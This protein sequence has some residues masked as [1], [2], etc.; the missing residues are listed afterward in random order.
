MSALKPDVDGTHDL[1][2]TALRWRA[3]HVDSITTAEAADGGA[4]C[5]IGTNLVV[6]GNLTVNGDTTTLSTSTLNVEDI[7]ITVANGAA[8]SAA[9]DG[10]GLLVDG[11]SASLL[12]SH[13]GTQWE[14]NK[15][16]EITGNVL[17][18]ANV[19]HDLG[20]SSLGWNDL[21]LGDGGV[22]QLGNDQDVTLTHIP[23]TG[24][25]LNDG[26]KLQFRDT[27]EYLHSDG[28]GSMTLEGASAVKLSVGTN[29][30]LSVDANSVDLAQ[31]LNVGD[32]TA[33]T[34]A[35][36]GALIV[37]GGMGLAGDAH[38]GGDLSLQH[39]AA[40]LHLGADDDVS[41]THVADTGLLLNSSRQLQFGDS[42][43]YIHQSADGQLDAVA[44]AELALTAPIV[45]IDASTA[46]RISNDLELDSDAAVLKFGADGDVSLT[47]VAD[48]GLLLN[49]SSQLRFR[50][51][52]LLVNSSA[53]GQLDINSDGVLALDATTEIAATTAT[54]DLDATGAFQIDG[55]SASNVTVDGGNLS[56]GTT[57]S[58]ELDLT[59]AG[60]L[61]INGAGGV[62]IDATGALSLDGS[63]GVNI[64]TAADVA[65][66]MNSAALDIDAS[67][68][69]TID[70]TS[71]ISIGGAAA[72]GD[73]SIGTNATSRNITVGSTTG[74]TALNLNAGSTG[75]RMGI[76]GATPV[77]IDA[78]TFDLD[79]SGAITVDGTST[80]SL[81]GQDDTNLTMT[82]NDGV[83]KT[84]TISA[85]NTGL[86]EGHLSLSSDSQVTVTDGTAS[87]TLNGGAS[88][89]SGATT[90]TLDSTN[91]LELNSS[92]GAISI[93]SDDV[94]Q[95]INIGT[96]GERTIVLGTDSGTGLVPTTKVDMNAA[97][98]EADA[99]SQLVLSSEG[100]ALAAIDIDSAGGLDVDA[101]SAIS[102]ATTGAA[103]HI[104]LVSAHTAGLAFHIDA[105]ANASSEVQID[106][107]IL[108]IDVTG[109]ADIDAG[110]SLS[111]QGG[112]ASDFTTSSGA[113]TLSG[114][115]G[116]NIV[117]NTSEIDISTG[118]TL[119]INSG[120]ATLDASSLSIDSTDTTNLTMT[121][122]VD[123]E[124]VLTIDALNNSTGGSASAKIVVGN[125]SGT[126]VQIGHTTSE[127]TIGQN[128]TVSGNLTVQ[129]TQTIVNTVTMEAANAIRFDGAT[130]DDNI[131][132][133]LTII[134]PDANRTIS[135]PNQSGC[136]P[137]LAATSATQ[138]TATP[139]ELN[140]V[141]VT[142]GT[143]AASKAL[144]LD[145]SSNIASIGTVGCGAITSTDA[146]SFGSMT[147][148]GRVQ[149]N[150]ETEATN[151]LDGSLQ[152][153]GGLSVAKSAVIGDDL[154]LLSDAAIISFGANK[155]V[156]LT[157][158][159]DTGLLLNGESQLQFRDGNINIKSDVDG[160]LNLDADASIDLSIGG[161][162]KLSI[163]SSDST[164][165]TNV[166]VPDGASIGSA[167]DTNA[168]TIASDGVVAVTSTVASTSST[169]GALKVAGGLGVNGKINAQR[170]EVPTGNGEDL[171]TKGLNLS[172]R[173]SDGS[174]QNASISSSGGAQFSTLTVTG[175][176]NFNNG[177]TLGDATSDI[178]TVKGFLNAEGTTTFK[179]SLKY[180]STEL[181]ISAGAVTA[182]KP[183]HKI[184]GEGDAS[185]D[186]DTINGGATGMILVIQAQ[187]AARTITVKHGTGNI[188]L[189]GA[190]DFALDNIVNTLSLIYNGS[191]WCEIGRSDI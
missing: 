84:L 114:G 50:D 109:N 97:T 14:L 162:D 132:T 133:T 98:I 82:A 134:D 111:L 118:G 176:V 156:T 52:G 51:A 36:T 179:G 166:I 90:L 85:S 17:P 16:L 157:H 143:A 169:T 186:L 28:V 171:I 46:V 127:V 122:D 44:D 160:S 55:G 72:A 68:A 5:T 190:A 33:S 10:A 77:D 67:G 170:L 73:I 39:D 78:T 62:D 130:G 58:G 124:R 64:G 37:D 71:T 168:I 110:S 115:D 25:R 47:H 49:A 26:M 19:T 184:D 27:T 93:G 125:T 145:A 81:D 3:L 108:D 59:S 142:P 148:S 128:L 15:P 131:F 34:S 75:I 60:L 91:A 18:Q 165:T 95:N 119:D 189:N 69:I 22:I 48:T 177:V 11:A 172:I 7:Q 126:A 117:G 30:V 2:T 20:S 187:D 107:G 70:G 135:L 76:A 116:V 175:G 112:A 139:E 121:A 83:D 54:F 99:G 103:G 79:A 155:D 100:V 92:A 31:P 106:A 4:D 154:D 113:L 86:G 45:D 182:A 66:D 151:L 146:S 1:G 173:N 105:N 129:G 149:V 12:Y 163:T 120:A 8:D 123:A 141:D 80:L 158:V 41:L 180:D 35:T 144:V 42:A 56:I 102:L 152:T 164:F 89:I 21:Y 88:S 188:Q 40:V 13:A 43:T 137:V 65:I 181:T 161:V 185:D 6:T 23:D 9:A 32:T 87:L 24:I 53:D 104:E 183:Y 74:A 178:T 167:S 191:N 61:D 29:T 174:S 38:F 138:I 57:T 159:H 153:D 94:D 63:T 147:T 96:D 136:L 140:Y 150:D 101:V